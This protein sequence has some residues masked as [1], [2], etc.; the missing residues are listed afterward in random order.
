MKYRNSYS[1]RRRFLSKAC[2]ATFGLTTASSS[3]FRLNS[4]KAAAKNNLQYLGDD[5]KA[6]VCLFQAGGSDSHNMLVPTDTSA[7]SEYAM[8]RTN[9][10]LRQDELLPLA[11]SN[12]DGRSFGLNA[13]MPGVQALF[14]QG[15]LA[16]INNVGTLI[17]PVNKVDYE[18]KSVPLPLGLFSHS[19]QIAQWQT[20]QPDKR[21]HQGWGGRLAEMF[22][23]MNTSAD[24]SMNIT[25]SGTNVFQ[26]ADKVV[27]YSVS[28]SGEGYGIRGYNGEHDFNVARTALIDGLLYHD[29]EDIYKKTYIDVLRNSIDAQQLFNETIESVPAFSTEFSNG[30][31]SQSFNMIAKIIASRE[32][33]GFKRQIFFVRVGGWDHHDD[34]LRRQNGMLGGVSAALHQFASV[35]QEINAFDEV[36]TFSMSEFGRTLTS[37]GDGSDHA[38][39]GN[40]MVMGGAVN[41]A[42]MYGDYP[43]LALDNPLEIGRGRIIPTLSNDEYFAE[44]ALWFG[45]AP[46]QLSTILPNIGN[47]YAGTNGQ[48]PIGFL[49]MS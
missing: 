1:S 49:E 38:W 16:F 2:L 11:H 9:L 25:L 42:T 24:I 37:N 10:A 40:V 8:T 13:S 31:L 47:F 23:E 19:D 44:L 36:L 20:A 30:Q 3:L 27:E 45:V 29:Y 5:Y 32:I 15:D 39:G 48:Q 21:V 17:Q 41:G 7:Y 14:N 26:F 35:L 4:V 6:L 22:Q 33:L 12:S 43:S 28:P 34:L 46:S 18:N